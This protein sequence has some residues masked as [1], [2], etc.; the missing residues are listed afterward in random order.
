MNYVS[1]LA[2]MLVLVKCYDIKMV[3]LPFYLVIT[4]LIKPEAIN[5]QKKLCVRGFWV[6]TKSLYFKGWVLSVISFFCV[7]RAQRTRNATTVFSKAGNCRRS[8]EIGCNNLNRHC[9]NNNSNICHWDLVPEATDRISGSRQEMRALTN[10]VHRMPQ[11]WWDNQPLF[12]SRT[13][14]FKRCLGPPPP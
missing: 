11:S 6:G 9:Y 1:L 7:N 5:Q 12:R 13:Q 10:R 3:L 8:V 14:V 2:L 4:S